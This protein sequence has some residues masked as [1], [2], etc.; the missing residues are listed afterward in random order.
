MRLVLDENLDHD[1]FMQL[2][3]D[4]YENYGDEIIGFLGRAP[5]EN[6]DDNR[7]NYNFIADREKDK[8]IRLASFITKDMSGVAGSLVYHWFG[9]DVYSF[10]TRFGNP[11]V[12]IT[13]L[14]ALNGFLFQPLTRN[15]NFRCV[16]TGNNLHES[17]RQF[18]MDNKSSIPVS[19]H[20]IVRLNEEFDNIQDHYTRERIRNLLGDS[21][22]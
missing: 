16:V 5:R 7:L 15:S 3:L 22:F 18:A 13:S 2:Y 14:R 6:N 12:S 1:T 9:Y 11:N 10:I 21:V 20:N 8:I 17:S 19:I 4:A